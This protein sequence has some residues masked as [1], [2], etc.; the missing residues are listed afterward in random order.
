[1]PKPLMKENNLNNI[2]N[3]N[4]K[5]LNKLNNKI[6]IKF[7]TSKNKDIFLLCDLEQM[8]RVIFNVIK[9]Q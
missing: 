7:T 1:M 6:E 4:I 3:N 9:I 2:I 8:N 5:L